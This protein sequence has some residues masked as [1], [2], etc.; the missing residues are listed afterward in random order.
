MLQEQRPP[1]P[2]SCHDG[3]QHKPNWA[4]RSAANCGYLLSRTCGGNAPIAYARAD[5]P[6]ARQVLAQVARILRDGVRICDTVGRYG[7]YEFIVILPQTN[8]TEARQLAQRFRSQLAITPIRSLRQ[9]PLTASI[10]VA[11]WTPGTCSEELLAAADSALLTA[12]G[13]AH[14]GDHRPAMSATAA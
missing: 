13:A 5:R 11:Q 9:Q 14:R 6:C 3:T 8:E 2:A 10:G 12:Q 1:R 7:G 4:K